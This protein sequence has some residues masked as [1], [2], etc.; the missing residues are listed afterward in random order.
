MSSYE[1]LHRRQGWRVHRAA[2][3]A[4]SVRTSPSRV[5]AKPLTW[6]NQNVQFMRAV[7]AFLSSHDAVTPGI[8]Y[9]FCG[10]LDVRSWDIDDAVND[11]R[12]QA[13]DGRPSG[14]SRD[15]QVLIS[16]ESSVEDSGRC[17]A[18]DD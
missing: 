8:R 14:Q 1:G 5:T 16:L 9:S 11:Q 18:S 4:F 3:K 13:V 6:A 10:R 2:L 15:V 12:G 7:P 17:S